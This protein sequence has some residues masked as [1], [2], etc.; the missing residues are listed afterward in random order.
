MAVDRSQNRNVI[1][2]GLIVLSL[3]ASATIIFFVPAIIKHLHPSIQ[4]VAVMGDAG[5]LK[6]GAPVW[7]GGKEVGVVDLV[8]VRGIG[9]DSAERVAVLV[10]IPEK[11]ADAIRRD[12]R[13]RITTQR[14]IGDPLVDIMPGSPSEPAIHDGDTIRARI[15]G[16]I[17]GLLAK[18]IALTGAFHTMFLE[19]GSF[20]KTAAARTLDVKR[21]NTD[22]TA[23]TLQ[24]H[25][26]MASLQSSPMH[27]SS[28]TQWRAIMD[29]LMATSREIQGA[30]QGAAKRARKARSDAAPSLERL[31]ARADTIT[32]EVTSLRAQMNAGGGGLFARAQKDSAIVKGIHGAQVQLDSLMAETKRN[33]LR[34]WF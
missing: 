27:F 8:D 11:Y 15:G 2:G 22:F 6:K 34:F 31:M 24:L 4:L 25:Q 17:A 3:L 1:I 26:L 33:P 14:M 21:L 12:S 20:K 10:R 28:D 13:V 7:I 30:L 32:A 16:T 23:A 5:A 18:S 9:V 19:S 29:H